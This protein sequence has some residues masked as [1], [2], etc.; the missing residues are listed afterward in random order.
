MKKL[1]IGLVLG[2]LLGA[3]VGFGAGIFI[4]PYWFLR[5]VA[6][7]QVTDIESRTVAATGEFIDV[8][9]ADPVHWGTGHVTIYGGDAGR[10]LL[11]LES[12]F[13]VGP[14]PRFHVYLV[15]RAEIGSGADFKA[16]QVVDLGRLKAFKGSQNY[17]IPDDLD[18]ARYGSVVVWCKEFDVLISPA[19]LVRG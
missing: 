18:L 13:E 4:Y 1:L 14:G 2:G 11:H 5:D 19:M 3:A 6:M 15:D 17:A 9:P 10:R 16:S 12:D 7:E 8:D